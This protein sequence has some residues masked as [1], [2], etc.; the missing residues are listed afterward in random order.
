MI[1]T[2]E[3]I[4]S[5]FSLP[6]AKCPDES[7]RKEFETPVIVHN[8]T[9]QPRKD[10]YYACPFC[11]TRI[12]KINEPIKLE[13]S[14]NEY[15]IESGIEEQPGQSLSEE[16]V[17]NQIQIP[18]IYK[19]IQ[20][21]IK[22]QVNT[23]ADVNE[24]DNPKTVDISSEVQKLE[25]E[26]MKLLKELDV[27]KHDAQEKILLLKKELIELRMQKEQLQAVVQE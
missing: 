13:P 20:H 3:V 27:L 22:E 1:L 6:Y 25:K 23:S 4:L 12:E 2:Q 9:Y 24:K 5:R 19:N 8:F 26:K 16:N 21:V 18:H 14:E 10:T 11:L 7:C 17:T 15:K